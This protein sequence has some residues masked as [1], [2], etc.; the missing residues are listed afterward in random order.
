MANEQMPS[1]CADPTL[2][3]LKHRIET[4]HE[5]FTEMRTVLKE[6]SAA[7]TRLAL[8]EERQ[9]QSNEAQ[10]RAFKVLSALEQ[11][12][13]DL[14]KRVPETNRTTLWL[15]RAALTAVAAVFLYV[16]KQVGLL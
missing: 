11:R 16:S 6:L 13:S 4:M 5:D 2:A 10:E 12:V 15:D 9:A 14:E 7:I 3:I 8:V 1:S